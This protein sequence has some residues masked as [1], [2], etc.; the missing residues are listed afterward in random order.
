MMTGMTDQQASAP[1]A[2]AAAD[3]S[4]SGEPD[5]E[6]GGWGRALDAAGI[7]AGLV[8]AAIIIDIFSDGRLIS[9]RLRREPPPEQAPDGQA[10]EAGNP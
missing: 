9:R 8:L 4:S 6:G 3:D 10:P 7:V 2:A 5:S 1:A